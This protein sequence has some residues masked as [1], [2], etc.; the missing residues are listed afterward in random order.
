MRT[1]LQKVWD[2][3]PKGN[4]LCVTVSCVLFL[5]DR[6]IPI[7]D[8]FKTQLQRGNSESGTRSTP[9]LLLSSFLFEDGDGVSRCYGGTGLISNLHSRDV[10]VE[11]I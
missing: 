10:E 2:G 8:E 3:G 5:A 7:D 4:L 1:Y 9:S 6:T 11:I